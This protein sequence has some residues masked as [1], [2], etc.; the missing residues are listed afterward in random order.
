MP[1]DNKKR[2]HNAGVSD[3]IKKFFYGKPYQES[4]KQCLFKEPN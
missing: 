3:D 1:N 4:S 2:R